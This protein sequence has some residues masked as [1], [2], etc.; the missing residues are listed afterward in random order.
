MTKPYGRTPDEHVNWFTS[1]MFM[2]FH[3]VPLAAIFTGVSARALVLCGVLYVTRLFFITA[4]YHRYF[5]HRSYRT[6]RPVQFL[7]ALGGL[8]A[9]QKGP[10][11]WAAHH[12]AHHRNSDTEQDPHTPMKGFRQSHI[13]WI[14]A[15]RYNA[16]DLAAVRDLARFPELRFLNRNDWI[17]PWAAGIACYL[18]AGWSGVVIGFFLSTVLLWHA[19]FTV[20]SLAHVFGRRRY[21]TD[22]TSRNSLAIALITGGEGWHNNH[23]HYQASARQGFFWWEID[24][25]YYALRALAL[26]RV[27][28]DLRRPPATVLAAPRIRAGYP[29]IGMIRAYWLKAA[30]VL[31]ASR[32]NLGGA[33]TDTVAAAGTSLSTQRARLEH[34]LHAEHEVLEATVASS[35]EAFENY[36]RLMRRRQ[37]AVGDTG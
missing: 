9:V 21:A 25:T 28:R 7:L 8:T 26:V 4:G 23:H 34:K 6:S 16:T 2:A 12:R 18:I 37:S 35:L 36:S 20:N 33:I 14:M 11:W 30:A 17:G 29:D 3:L 27:V 32:A 22:D 13:G 31:A 1:A 15:D 19:T 24:M 5:S 10:L